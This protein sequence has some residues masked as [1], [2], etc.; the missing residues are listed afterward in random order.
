[1]EKIPLFSI[2]KYL[3]RKNGTLVSMKME[4]L[5]TYINGTLVSTL[6]EIPISISFR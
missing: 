5:N 3:F 6:C 4:H 2:K 1:M